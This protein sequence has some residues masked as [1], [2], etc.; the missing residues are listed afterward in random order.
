MRRRL[1][2]ARVPL[3]ILTG[4][5]VT[6]QDI[7]TK[8]GEEI[9]GGGREENRE[10][11]AWK[12]AHVKRANCNCVSFPFATLNFIT[13]RYLR[14][15]KRSMNYVD[16]RGYRA[17]HPRGSHTYRASRC[18][19]SSTYTC[20]PLL[21]A[22]RNARTPLVVALLLLTLCTLINVCITRRLQVIN[23]SALVVR[24]SVLLAR[25]RT[26]PTRLS[27]FASR[28]RVSPNDSLSLLRRS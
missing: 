12:R 21:V 16:P 17:G 19:S 15:I 18:G 6:K 8:S 28:S 26:A 9:R 3:I 11:S 13:G 14:K 24:F 27:S 23:Y 7:Y 22:E 20:V 10:A 2:W 5:G 25:Y 1:G 4:A